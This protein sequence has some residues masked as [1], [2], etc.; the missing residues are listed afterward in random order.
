M[1]V[2]AFN[3]TQNLS[4]VFVSVFEPD[5]RPHWPGNLKK[6][7]LKNGKLTGVGDA[8]AVDPSTGF[9]RRTPPVTSYWSDAPDGDDVKLGGAANQLPDWQSRKL[10]SNLT[11]IANVDLND[12]NNSVNV[13]SAITGPSLGIANSNNQLR[14]AVIEW[15]RGRDINNADDDVNTDNRNQMGA[16]LHVAPVTMIYGGTAD[17]PDA[18]VFTST[19]DGYVHAVSTRTGIEEWSF[20]PSHLLNKTYKLFLKREIEPGQ[21]W[22]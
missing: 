20:L 1:P 16:G 21:L 12:G 6:Y 4:D 5:N 9:F 13:A 11:G 10:Y 2:N 7:K 22:S 15:M 17:D 14:Q 3:R 8:L 18:L 19:N